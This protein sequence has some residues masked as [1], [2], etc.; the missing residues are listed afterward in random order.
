[1][2][3]FKTKCFLIL[4]NEV[5]TFPQALDFQLLA[6]CTLPDIP[7]VIR[8]RLEVTGGI[9][10]TRYIRVVLLSAFDWFVHRNRG[11]HEAFFYLAKSLET[12]LQLKMVVRITFGNRADNGDVVAPRTDVVCGG[13]DGNIDV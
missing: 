5:L 9:V 10:A 8:G 12:G 11:S 6:C 13:Y 7:D 2:T 3:K 4:S 1:M